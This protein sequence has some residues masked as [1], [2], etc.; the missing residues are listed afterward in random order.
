MFRLSCQI[1]LQDK[2]PWLTL[3][4]YGSVPGAI[5]RSPKLY[6]GRDAERATGG[7]YLYDWSGF[8][9]TLRMCCAQ[10]DKKQHE[11]YYILFLICVCSKQVHNCVSTPPPAPDSQSFHNI[12]LSKQLTTK[13]TLLFPNVLVCLLFFC[14]V[15]CFDFLTMELR[16]IKDFAGSYWQF[17]LE[18]TIKESVENGPRL[19]WT[20]TITWLWRENWGKRKKKFDIKDGLMHLSSHHRHVPK[21]IVL[22]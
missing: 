2:G 18:C 17:V 1:I 7:L 22:E 13:C 9:Y 8:I 15:I 20:A 5:M 16:L 3:A 21:C 10:R 14:L 12:M 19:P 6:L 11:Y 4:Q